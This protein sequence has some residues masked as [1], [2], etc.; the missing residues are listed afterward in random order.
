MPDKRCADIAVLLFLQSHGGSNRV[1]PPQQRTYNNGSLATLDSG[2]LRDPSRWVRTLAYRSSSPPP[3]RGRA[4]RCRRSDQLES[5]RPT[6]SLARVSSSQSV[7]AAPTSALGFAGP[8]DR[9][10]SSAILAWNHGYPAAVPGHR[11]WEYRA[12]AELRC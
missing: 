10:S 7:A 4:R 3:W 11:F 9:L 12:N 8:T 5:T 1:W 6:L 2:E